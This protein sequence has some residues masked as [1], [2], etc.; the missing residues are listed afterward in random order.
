MPLRE[1]IIRISQ[2]RGHCK[3]TRG[4]RAKARFGEVAEDR[5]EGKAEVRAS[6]R[7]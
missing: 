6:T 4:H 3:A 1:F 2:G 5:K 7:V